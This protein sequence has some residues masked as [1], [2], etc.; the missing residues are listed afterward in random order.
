[1]PGVCCRAAL[2]WCKVF[3]VVG[4]VGFCG[5]CEVGC[6]L[7][8][9]SGVGARVPRDVHRSVRQEVAAGVAEFV[10]FRGVGPG[11]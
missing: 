6:V 1:M 4:G 10:V 11:G 5:V 8:W 7:S 9:G 3:S 2:V